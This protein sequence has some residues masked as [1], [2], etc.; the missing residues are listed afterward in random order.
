MLEPSESS[1]LAS[2]SPRVKIHSFSPEKITKHQIT[3]NGH[4]IEPPTRVEIDNIVG[5]KALKQKRIYQR[6]ADLTIVQC[7][8][9]T[10]DLNL[11]LILLLA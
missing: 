3:F 11:A 2:K 4:D 5:A 8:V 9:V 10:L 7:T 6:I 1:A